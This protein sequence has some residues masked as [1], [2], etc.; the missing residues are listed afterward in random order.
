MCERVNHWTYHLYQ[1]MKQGTNKL[2][3]RPEYIMNFINLTRIRYGIK[4][5]YRGLVSQNLLELWCSMIDQ[6]FTVKNH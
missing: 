4:D 6:K 3:N 1:R 5:V 2:L